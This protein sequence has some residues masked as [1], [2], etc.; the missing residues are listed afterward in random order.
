MTKVHV[1][2]CVRACN[3]KGIDKIVNVKSQ[4]QKNSV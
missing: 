2:A 3:A 1:C 4:Y